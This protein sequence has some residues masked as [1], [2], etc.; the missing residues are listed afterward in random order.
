L[1]LFVQIGDGGPG[2]AAFGLPAGEPGP[3]LTDIDLKSD[4]IFAAVP[5]LPSDLGSALLPQ[6][7]IR[8]LAL[9]GAIPEVIADGRLVSLEIDTTGFFGG[10][11]PL[12]LTDVLPFAQFGGPWATTFASSAASLIENG[13]VSIDVGTCDTDGDGRCD[14]LGDLNGNELLDAGDIDS[15]A[16]AIRRGN[17]E[18]MLD[19]NDDGSVDIL[20]HTTWIASLRRTWPG[21]ANLNGVF[22]SSDLVQVFAVGLYEVRDAVEAGWGSGDWNGDGLF[23]TADMVA[24]F[25]AG[26]YNQGPRAAASAVPEP[27]GGIL[28]CFAVLGLLCVRRGIGRA[29]ASKYGT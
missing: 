15:L 8:T 4:T 14:P 9:V 19:L 18:R 17:V 12:K 20:D 27:G 3:A 6:V 26:G 1:D 13:S 28:G 7:G 23:S 10:S 24:V 21:D 22:D 5:D 2:L 11:W 25:Q 16:A 29:N